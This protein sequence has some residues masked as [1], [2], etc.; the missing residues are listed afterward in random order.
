MTEEVKIPMK[1]WKTRY[2]SIL[3]TAG[4]VIL[5][6]SDVVPDPTAKEWIKFAGTV[7]TGV[8]TAMAAW[9]IGHKIEKA[10]DKEC[11]DPPIHVDPPLTDLE[12][13]QYEDR[14]KEQF[15]AQHGSVVKG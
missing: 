3:L 6:A 5:G 4:T 10:G 11:L 1:G 8:G 2:G 9:G 12:K 14:I 15:A 13:K 7:I